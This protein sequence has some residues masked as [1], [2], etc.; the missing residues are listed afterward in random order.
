VENNLKTFARWYFN[1]L[2]QVGVDYAD[3]KEVQAYDLRMQK[4]RDVNKEIQ[5]IMSAINLKE[6][7]VILEIGTGTGELAVEVSKYCKKV[8]ALDI[9]NTML[10][11]ARQKAV[12]RGRNNI[13]FI[14]GGFLTYEHQE[15][16]LDTVVSQL[17]LHHLPDFWKMIALRRV[18]EMLKD[19][20]KLFLR[21]VVFPSDVEDYEK[22]FNELIIEI[23]ENAG[24]EIAEETE[25]HIKEEFSTLDWIAEELLKR[26]G[27]RIDKADYYN[28]FLAT[29]VCTKIHF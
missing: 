29:Y 4:I 28:G 27:F 22:F 23:R 6:E 24:D 13:E 20:G 21:D 19:G 11:F 16:L 5:D 17:A 26:A 3:I 2:Q 14:R 7:H 1:E 12:F 9:S 15:G 10:E 18:F 25:I 8:I